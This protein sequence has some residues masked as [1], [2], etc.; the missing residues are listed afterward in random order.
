MPGLVDG[1]AH[2]GHGLIKTMGGG[3][4]DLWYEACELAYTV[5][6]TPEFW[7]AEAQL[8]ALERLRFGVTTGVSLLGGGD[9]DHAHRRTRLRRRALRGRRS[10]VGTRSV[11]AIGPT[12]PPHPRTYARWNGDAK[13]R[14][15]VDFDQQIATCHTLVDRWHGKHG[16]RVNIAML[17]PTLREEH[18]DELGASDARRGHRARPSRRAGSAA[19]AASSSRR[20][21]TPRAA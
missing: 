4:S 14:F 17:T 15:P 8:A 5:G 3:R 19:S 20:T 1:H 7:R 10:A 6:S 2:A 16:K 18:R 21:A 12:R 11:V 13:Q 9:T